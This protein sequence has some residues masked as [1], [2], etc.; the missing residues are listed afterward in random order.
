[1]LKHIPSKNNGIDPITKQDIDAFFGSPD[2]YHSNLVRN[3]RISPRDGTVEIEPDLVE[4]AEYW[5]DIP[6]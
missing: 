2:T 3:Y 5:D 4:R 6:F 1:M